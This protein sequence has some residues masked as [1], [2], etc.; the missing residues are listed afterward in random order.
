VLVPSHASAGSECVHHA[1]DGASAPVASSNAPGSVSW[2]VFEGP[3]HRP[4][5]PSGLN[6]WFRFVADVPPAACELAT[7]GRS[8]RQSRSL[9][10]LGRR[11]RSLASPCRGRA[12]RQSPTIPAMKAAPKSF[13]TLPRNSFQF[14]RIRARFTPM[15]VCVVCVREPCFTVRHQNSNL[16]ILDGG[17]PTSAVGCLFPSSRR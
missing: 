10:Q 7:R 2:A 14:F 8:A 17:F 4:V 3:K 13:T 1:G 11:C 9:R 16:G 12:Y 6:S 15:F 5:L